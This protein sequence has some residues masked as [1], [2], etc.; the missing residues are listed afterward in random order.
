MRNHPVSRQR[1]KWGFSSGDRP[2]LQTPW[3]PSPLALGCPHAS[4]WNTLTVAPL[5]ADG[6][7]SSLVVTEASNARCQCGLA[8]AVGSELPR[9]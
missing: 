2:S 7:R 1:S 4:R 9:C 8:G 5:D 6:E 3:I